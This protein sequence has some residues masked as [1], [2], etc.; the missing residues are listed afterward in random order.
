MNEMAKIAVKDKAAEIYANEPG[1]THEL[2][3]KRC[4]ITPAQLLTLRKDPNFWEKVYDNY[5]VAYSGVLPRVLASMIR[6]AESGNVQA[7][8]LV[9]EHSGK[10]VKNVNV[11]VDSPFDKWLHKAQR[12]DIQDAEIVEEVFEELPES[13]TEELPPRNEEDQNLRMQRESKAIKKAVKTAEYNAKRREWY[14]WTKRA[15]KVGIQPL[16]AA[17]PTK[18]QRK[19]W[20][21]SII[22]AEIDAKQESKAKK[23][24]EKK[25]K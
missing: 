3:A 25:E 6:E 23:A 7:A 21:E 11:T 1:V 15:K 17:K 5:M 19:E 20:E 16:K 13:P 4:G 18:G 9:L 10:L 24:T 2:V 8:R 12:V 14:K 22:R